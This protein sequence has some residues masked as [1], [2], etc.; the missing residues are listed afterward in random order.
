M[1]DKIVEAQVLESPAIINSLSAVE[2]INRAEFDMQISTAKRFPR[3]ISRVKSEIISF[4]SLDEETAESCFYSL[5]RGGKNIQGPSVRLA[6]IAVSCYGNLRVGTRIVDTVTTGDNPH[7]VV[8]A[9]CSDLQKNV[10]VC[11][12]KRRR[13]F[14]KASKARI[15]EDDINLAVNAGSAIA[16]RDAVFKIVPG[17]LIKVALDQAKKVAIGDAKSLGDRRIRA[18][19]SLAKIGVTK[20]RILSFLDKKSADEV[21]LD[22][23]EKLFGAHT[24]IKD[25]QALIDEVFPSITVKP[26]FKD[27]AP[28]D[29]AKENKEP[30]AE[31]PPSE[32]SIELIRQKLRDQKIDE[33]T[34]TDH[35]LKRNYLP[36]S[37]PIL[38]GLTDEKALI[39]ANTFEAIVQSIKN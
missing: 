32:M 15:D 30:N 34:L 28:A 26:V 2:A 38:E 31:I 8:Q 13:I 7:V 22:D 11:I 14:K 39:V 17:A 19:E 23:L 4:A 35:L 12:E 16:F 36:K 20:E 10:A 33:K 37:N 21:D 27:A 9:V 18:F 24:A 6:E 25:G 1:D 3:E 5:P 29:K